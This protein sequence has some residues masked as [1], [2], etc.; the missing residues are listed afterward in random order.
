MSGRLGKIFK[1]L[2]D[3]LN[4]LIGVNKIEYDAAAVKVFD[5]LARENGLGGWAEQNPRD[6]EISEDLRWN[7][8]VQWFRAQREYLLGLNL[9]QMNLKGTVDLS[10]L[11]SIER[12]YLSQNALEGLALENNK[13]LR[14]LHAAGNL[15][16]EVDLCGAPGLVE[17]DFTGNRLERLNLKDCPALVTVCL[18]DNQ[19][20]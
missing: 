15:I 6:W 10:G 8:G 17:I 11:E 5:R 19:L 18:S 13:S 1:A 3:T 4:S 9:C 7:Q 12:L 20:M 16:S 14:E 2:G